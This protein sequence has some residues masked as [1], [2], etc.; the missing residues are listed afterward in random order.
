MHIFTILKR[1]NVLNVR[2]RK[3]LI[4][5]TISIS[6][7]AVISLIILNNIVV[8][9][10]LYSYINYVYVRYMIRF[11]MLFEIFLV[12]IFSSVFLA[13]SI[14]T[15]KN[16]NSLQ[17]ILC[18]E[19]KKMDIIFGKYIS[20]VLNTACIV[21]AGLPVAYISLFFGGFTVNRLIKFLMILFMLILL[22]NAISL[23]VSSRVKDTMVS[24]MLCLMV[25]ALFMIFLFFFTDYLIININYTLIFVLISFL[26]T[27]FLLR[28][29]KSGAMFLL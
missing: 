11:A 20:G 14:N 2:K 13:Q 29:T 22:A 23:F 26:L 21:F 6:L 19:V 28:Y 1:E 7:F 17:N 18:T 27:M 12:F 3:L 16:N 15:D 4:S 9:A 5:L 25:F 10:D 24:L 8:E